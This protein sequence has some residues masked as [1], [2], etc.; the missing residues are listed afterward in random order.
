[1]IDRGR[2]NL[3]GVRIHAVDY[4]AAVSQIMEAARQRR[5]F[6]VSA[7]A[8]HGVMTGTLDPHHRHRL[9]ELELIVPDGQPVRWGLNLL[10]QTRLPDRVYGP[11]LMLQVC[12]AACEA[13]VPIFL[14]GSTAATLHRLE[15]RLQRQFPGLQVA[16][17]RASRF[18]KLTHEE[19]REVIREIRESGAAITLVGLGCPRQEVWTYEFKDHLQ[20]PV[21]AVG[22]A[23]AFHAGQLS[24]APAWMQRLGLEWLFRLIKEPRRLWKRYCYLNPRFLWLLLLQKSGMRQFRPDDAVPPDGEVLYG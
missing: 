21:L 18:R 11:N 16:G 1:M 14:F 6:G 23:F 10:H 8:V 17:R 15:N 2:P 12:R 3:L 5:P 22:A 20:M 19:K 4:E 13:G 7:L 9:N 24:Q